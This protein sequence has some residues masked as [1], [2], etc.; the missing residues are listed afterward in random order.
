[1]RVSRMIFSGGRLDFIPQETRDRHHVVVVVRV[2]T[3]V[4]AHVT[5]LVTA[6]LIVRVTVLVIVSAPLVSTRR[7]ITLLKPRV[8]GGEERSVLMLV[9]TCPVC[10]TNLT[11]HNPLLHKLTL[12]RVALRAAGLRARTSL[13][14]KRPPPRTAVGPYA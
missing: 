9:V 11:L 2:T 3:L 8:F 10:V 1:M 5:A 12:Q 6:R 4:T 13:I 7:I 14:R